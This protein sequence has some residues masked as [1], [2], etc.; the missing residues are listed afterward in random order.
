MSTNRPSYGDAIQV[1][2]MLRMLERR[3]SG[4]MPVN[5]VAE[6]LEVHRR[7]VIRYVKALCQVIMNDHGEPLV[8]LV[9]REGE[10]WVVLNRNPA[11]V[12]SNVFQYAAIHAATS[13]LAAVGDPVLG[14]SARFVLGRLEDQMDV[15]FL[16][17]VKNGFY[18]VP[19]GPKNYDANEDVLDTITQAVLRCRP[20]D[21]EYQSSGS[22]EPKRR[23]IEPYTVVMYRDGLYVLAK[24]GDRMSLFAI[25]R[26]RDADLD[27]NAQFEVPEGFNPAQHFGKRLGI[28]QTT[29]RPV[30]VQI[31]FAKTAARSAEE[32]R[33][34]GFRGWRDLDDGRRVLYLRIPITPEVVTWVRTWGSEAEVIAPDDLRQAVCDDLQRAAALYS[35]PAPAIP[36]EPAIEAE[37][38]EDDADDD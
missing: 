24:T 28:W 36:S 5:L 8:D 37:V 27:R 16:E 9:R 33:W 11:P 22:P 2:L 18:Y 26:I 31:A 3:T 7:T 4:E 13:H 17:R 19:F 10:T 25:D 32:R 6:R 1:V 23:R 14:D 15:R 21:I 12:S 30:D 35:Q 38:D 29:Q 34:P 20:V